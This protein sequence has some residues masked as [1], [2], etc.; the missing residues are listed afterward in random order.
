VDPA[1][2][3]LKEEGEVDALQ[4]AERE[5]VATREAIKRKIQQAAVTT[6]QPPPLPTKL[7]I[8]PDDPDEVVSTKAFYYC[9]VV[10]RVNCNL[11]LEFLLSSYLRDVV[12]QW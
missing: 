4:E 5:A 10:V 3:R 9:M 1:N 8:D 2:V 11:S 7:R 6:F 12:C